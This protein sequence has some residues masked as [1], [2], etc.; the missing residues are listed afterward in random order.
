MGLPKALK[1]KTNTGTGLKEPSLEEKKQQQQKKAQE[2]EEATQNQMGM[3]S[4]NG[5]YRYHLLGVLERINEGQ[6]IL[7]NNIA[8]LIEQNPDNEA[9]EGQGEDLDEPPEPDDELDDEEQD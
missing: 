4:Q 7:N 6:N 8:S 2:Q 1:K 5:Y 9:E 3:L